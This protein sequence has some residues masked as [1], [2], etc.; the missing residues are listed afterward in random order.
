MRRFLAKLISWYQYTL[1][2]D[3]GLFSLRKHATCG[4]YPSCSEYTK[5]AILK[6]GVFKGLFWGAQRII[7]CHPWQTPQED[8]VP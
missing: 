6:H 7:R 3:T 2:P 8:L 1:S 5:E 4:F